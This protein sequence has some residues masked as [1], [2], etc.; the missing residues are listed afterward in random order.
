MRCPPWSSMGTV[1]RGR[2]AA[3]PPVFPTHTHRV[4]RRDTGTSAEGS[5]RTCTTL[6]RPQQN[7]SERPGTAHRGH[8]P[9]L[10]SLLS[11]LLKPVS[12]A[13]SCS[14]NSLLPQEPGSPFST[15]SWC[16]P[17]GAVVFHLEYLLSWLRAL[18]RS[19]LP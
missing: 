17:P 7:T 13:Q 14:Q 4:R 1:P 12:R 2:P 18:L 6:L 16:F 10:P 3:P 9:L 8:N 11:L 15:W 19:C 5:E